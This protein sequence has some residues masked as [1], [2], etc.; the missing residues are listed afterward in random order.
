M[1]QFEQLWWSYAIEGLTD[2]PLR[3]I[4]MVIC[5]RMFQWEYHQFLGSFRSFI[6]RIIRKQATIQK[7]SCCCSRCCFTY[8]HISCS[9]DIE[10]SMAGDQYLKKHFGNYHDTHASVQPWASQSVL[11]ITFWKPTQ[12]VLL[13]RYP[14]DW[15]QD[16][17]NAMNSTSTST[18]WR[19]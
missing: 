7:G 3:K 8:Q 9:L 17:F 2:D 11:T 14:F 16:K 18:T 4:M 5:N 15:F 13:F 12:S 1:S 19:T 10:P 6:Y